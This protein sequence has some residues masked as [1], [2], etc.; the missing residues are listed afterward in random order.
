MSSIWAWAHSRIPWGVCEKEACVC[1]I[2]RGAWFSSL[3]KTRLGKR[4]LA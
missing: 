1:V 3:S 2:V 4:E